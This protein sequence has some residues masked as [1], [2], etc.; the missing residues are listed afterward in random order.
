MA[1]R[2]IAHK[3]LRRLFEH[4]QVRG[5]PA[6]SADKLRNMLFAIDTASRVAD[7]AVFQS[8]KL[9]PLTGDLVGFWSQTV[10]RNWRLVFRFDDGDAFDLELLDYH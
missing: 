5:L 2:S 3:G 4:D 8:W 9:H 7:V 10:T 1:I 6:H